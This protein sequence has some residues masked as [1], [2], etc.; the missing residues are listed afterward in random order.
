MLTANRTILG[1]RWPD[2]ARWLEAQPAAPASSVEGTPH[3]TFAVHGIQLAGGFDPRAEAE[4]QARLVP[5]DADRAACYGIG[6]GELPRALLR[7]EALRAL[8]VVLFHPAV[9]RTVL[10]RVDLADWLAEPRVT[11]VR[12]RD[13]TELAPPFA[14]APADLRL[15]DAASARLRDLVLL[16]LATPHIH[17]HLRA[18]EDEV[19]RRFVANDDLLRADGDVAELF[20]TRRGASLFV[21]A[22]GPS[23]SDHFDLLRARGDRPLLAV[24]GALRAL[25]AAGVR[26]DIVL[27]MDAHR[28]GPEVL[29]AVE[30]AAVADTVLVYDPVVHRAALEAWGGRRLVMYGP[31]PRH[32]ELRRTLPK[33]VL[34]SSGSVTHAAAALAVEMGAAEVTFC[35]ADFAT[36]DGESHVQGFAWKKQLA[37]RGAGGPRVA[38]AAGEM[39]P[40]LPNLI[41]YL[42][43]LERFLAHHP[44]VRWVNAGRRGAR[45][46]GTI[47]REAAGG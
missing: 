15:A 21:A 19:A 5:A 22:A 10:A 39:V 37:D 44:E 7:R 2:V 23:L 11:L 20:G 45:I 28:Q 17:R 47:H 33:G 13:L 43:D 40:S 9:A 46:A 16:E 41:G 1:E 42:R 38:N 27:T 4:L 29:L 24:D 36:L 34:W 6:Q 8:D 32:A 12:A 31:G 25:L 30:P 3:P 18:A 14:A 26:P 35:G